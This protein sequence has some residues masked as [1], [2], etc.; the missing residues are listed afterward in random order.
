MPNHDE[1]LTQERP[2]VIIAC[3]VLRS[4]ILE[5]LEA[6][7]PAGIRLLS[8]EPD[9]GQSQQPAPEPPDEASITVREPIFLEYGL[10]R[11]P[12]LMAPAIQEQIDALPE[13]S[14][15]V[16]GYGLCGNGVVGVKAREHTLLIPRTDDCIAMFL[17][18]Y[19]TY[20]E[21]FASSPGT[22]YLTK[23]WLES[24]SHPLSEYHEYREKYGGDDAEWLIDTQYQDYERLCFVAHSAEDLEEYRPQALEVA[25][26][27]RERWGWRYE[28][29]LGTDRFIRQLMNHAVALARGQDGGQD[30]GQLDGPDWPPADADASDSPFGPPSGSAPNSGR[31]PVSVLAEF[32]A[33]FAVIPPGGEIRQDQL[34]RGLS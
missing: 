10:H 25:E 3:K 29:R 23:G 13:P 32:E 22:Y 34:L 18:S 16:I 14:L 33:N 6:L 30:G 11:F 9:E 7:A 19:E 5:R 24:G 28:E 26:F 17:G 15:V 12:Q 1:L 21:E 27:G 31:A 8:P 2:I 20:L 4:I